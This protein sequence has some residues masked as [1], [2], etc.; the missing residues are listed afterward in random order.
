MHKNLGMGLGTSQA[1]SKTYVMLSSVIALT[2]MVMGGAMDLRDVR[3]WILP[4]NKQ[5]LFCREDSIT[6]SHI[7]ASTWDYIT[8]TSYLSFRYT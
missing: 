2:S 4:V 3:A 1:T 5:C 8:M 7:I 6:S